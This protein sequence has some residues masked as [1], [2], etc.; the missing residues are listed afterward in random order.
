MIGDDRK[1]FDRSAAEFAGLDRFPMHQKAK[2]RRGAKS[3]GVADFHHLHAAPLIAVA[4][5]G[6]R[7]AHVRAARQPLFQFSQR[8]WFGTGEKHG[9]DHTL[10]LGQR[11]RVEQFLFFRFNLFRHA[12]ILLAQLDGGEDLFL[13]DLHMPLFDQLQGGRKGRSGC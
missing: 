7:L 6:H 1:R 13:P 12:S 3:I 11:G 10:L 8:D 4:Q 5:K 9:F 2:V